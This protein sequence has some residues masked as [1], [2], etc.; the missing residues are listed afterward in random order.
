MSLTTRPS[1]TPPCSA[2]SVNFPPSATTSPSLLG[3]PGGF[4]KPRNADATLRGRQAVFEAGE[5]LAGAGIGGLWRGDDAQISIVE[6]DGAFIAGRCREGH[7]PGVVAEHVEVLEGRPG[8]RCHGRQIGH[9]L[10]SRPQAPIDPVLPGAVAMGHGESE[11]GSVHAYIAHQLEV[12]AAA[13][14]RGGAV[15][16]PG[17]RAAG[18]PVETILLPDREVVVG[19]SSEQHLP[20]MHR[21]VAEA[22]KVVRPAARDGGGAIG[23]HLKAAVTVTIDAAALREAVFIDE[24]E[25][26]VIER[27]APKVLEGDAG[28]RPEGVAVGDPLQRSPATEI[29]TVAETV[30]IG[31]RADEGDFVAVDGHVIERQEALPGRAWR[32]R[33]RIAA[34]DDLLQRRLRSQARRAE[35]D[36][37]DGSRDRGPSGSLPERW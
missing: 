29:N 18:R 35:A 25:H 20:L 5:V 22:Q 13:G 4:R 23:D 16:H 21:D 32:S 12:A 10:Q 1:R 2:I 19:T 6:V 31:R 33:H 30:Q 11:T 36:D 37:Q 24:G 15:D 8:V 17:Q 14:N 28:T 3:W 27:H 7:R 34:I 9:L 26:S